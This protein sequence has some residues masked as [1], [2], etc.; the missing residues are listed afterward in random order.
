MLFQQQL[1]ACC[2]HL[3]ADEERCDS[4]PAASLTDTKI[5]MNEHRQNIRLRM[6][7]FYQLAVG[8]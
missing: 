6:S 4:S 8:K 3:T 5:K 2:G 7:K 1:P